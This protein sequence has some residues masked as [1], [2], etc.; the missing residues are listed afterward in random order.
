MHDS[1]AH[2]QYYY[3][4]IN[5]KAI[6]IIYLLGHQNKMLFSNHNEH[7]INRSRITHNRYKLIYCDYDGIVVF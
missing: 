2:H 7:T 1:D 6:N 4:I 3:M 5:R